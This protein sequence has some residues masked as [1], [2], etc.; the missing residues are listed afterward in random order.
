MSLGLPLTI[1]SLEEDTEF[2][3]LEMG[4]SAFGEI[5]FL[6]NLAKPTFAVI[7][8]IGEAHMQDLGSRE[9]ITKAKFEIIVRLKGRRK[10]ILRWR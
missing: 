2:A 6:S 7:T 8:N 3:V 5:E 1:F 4:M 9:G 10:I